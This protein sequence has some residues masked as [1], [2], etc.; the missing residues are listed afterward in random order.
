MDGEDEI[1][2]HR[3]GVICNS[4]EIMCPTVHAR[5]LTHNNTVP[6]CIPIEYICDGMEDCPHNTDFHSIDEKDCPDCANGAFLCQE[7]RICI[8][9]RQLCNGQEQCFTLWGG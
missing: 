7:D 1:G 6:V 3:R 9:E 8:A 5:F 4:T 2:C